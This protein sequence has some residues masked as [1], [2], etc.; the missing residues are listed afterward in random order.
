MF[1]V[2]FEVGPLYEEGS[3]DE[4]GVR[5]VRVDEGVVLL[6][7]LAWLGAGEDTEREDGWCTGMG[8]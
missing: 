8:S 4:R 3:D 2:L 1:C 6:L 5:V 7:T